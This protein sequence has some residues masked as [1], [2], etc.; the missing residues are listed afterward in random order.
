MQGLV[1]LRQG[2]GGR[3]NAWHTGAWLE[4]VTQSL[5]PSQ[6]CRRAPYINRSCTSRGEELA[7]S[8]D[9]YH[10]EASTNTPLLYGFPLRGAV[11]VVGRTLTLTLTLT[12]IGG[13]FGAN[14]HPNL[15]GRRMNGAVSVWCL[16][17]LDGEVSSRPHS[18]SSPARWLL[19]VFA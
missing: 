17:P 14:P 15:L 18:N 4:G 2:E 7:R 12:L 1:C 10:G 16:A 3:Y 8:G 11:A 19:G 9:S 5:M 13:R 6:R